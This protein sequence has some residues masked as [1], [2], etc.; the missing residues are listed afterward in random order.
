MK[1]ISNAASFLHETGLLAE[2]NR[3]VLHPRGLALSIIAM[4]RLEKVDDYE[5]TGFGAL[6]DKRDDEGIVLS[7]KDLE[8]GMARFRAAEAAGTVCVRPLREER[9]GY[10]VQP[11]PEAAD[12]DPTHRPE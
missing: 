2:I 9:L 6:Y 4:P 3:V 11:A 10:V 1:V 12:A 8:Q 5:V 7:A